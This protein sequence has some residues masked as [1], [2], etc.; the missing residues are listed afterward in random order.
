[1]GCPNACVFC[2]QRMISGHDKPDFTKVKGEIEK[3][4]ET[5]DPEKQDIQIAF[6]GGSFTGIDRGDML[7]L[8]GT[9]KEFI[10]EKRV[11]SVRLSTSR[12]ISTK[13]L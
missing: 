6:F 13:K 8:L 4:L 5:T 1:M 2:N 10:D 3:A 7:F 11:S 9:A 12:I